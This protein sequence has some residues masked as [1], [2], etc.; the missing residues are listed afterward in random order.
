MS[1]GTD[2]DMGGG[3]WR[4]ELAGGGWKDFAA[5]VSAVLLF[6]SVKPPFKGGRAGPTG[7]ADSATIKPPYPG[8]FNLQKSKTAFSGRRKSTLY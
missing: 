7:Q 6:H 3:G 4:L 5:R 2:S 8:L 1:G